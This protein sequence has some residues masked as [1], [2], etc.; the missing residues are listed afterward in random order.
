[1]L[2]LPANVDLGPVFNPLHVSPLSSS[3]CLILKQ[4]FLC[5]IMSCFPPGTSDMDG[6][7]HQHSANIEQR[8]E[9]KLSCNWRNTSGNITYHVTVIHRGI[10]SI[11]PSSCPSI[12]SDIQTGS[13]VLIVWRLPGYLLSITTQLKY[14]S[15][16]NQSQ[17]HLQNFTILKAYII[18]CKYEVLCMIK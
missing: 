7:Y 2:I 11:H 8:G 9:E 1:M 6:I 14:E 5:G 18:S 16:Q 3:V 10:C 17:M 13:C 12:S 4:V 15:A